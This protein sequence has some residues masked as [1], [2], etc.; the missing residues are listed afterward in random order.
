MAERNR[1]DE[2]RCGGQCRRD[3]RSEWHS[4]N[5]K[6]WKPITLEHVENKP[7]RFETEQELRSYC[8]EKG[9]A[10]SALL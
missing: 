9:L 8:K 5:A 10:S 3:P 2:C 6:I 7:R 4:V 1:V